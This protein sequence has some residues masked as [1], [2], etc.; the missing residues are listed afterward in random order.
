MLRAV[1]P[2]LIIALLADGP[3]IASRWPGRYAAAFA[4]DPGS[5]VLTL[6]SAGMSLSLEGNTRRVR[7]LRR[8]CS[9]AGSFEPEYGN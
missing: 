3:Q 2:N 1:G 8:D 9:L 5:S 4:D 6:T 7:S